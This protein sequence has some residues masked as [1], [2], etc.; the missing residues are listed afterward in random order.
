MRAANPA[1]G[2]HA[3]QAHDTDEQLAALASASE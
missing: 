3:Q 1:P 2:T